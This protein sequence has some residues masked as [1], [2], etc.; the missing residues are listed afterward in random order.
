MTFWLLFRLTVGLLIRQRRTLLLV[1]L[2]LLP[3][4]LALLYRLAADNSAEDDHDFAVALLAHLILG[5]VLPLTA[6]VVGTAAFGNELEDGTAVYLI[7]KPVPRRNIVLAKIAAAWLAI[8]VMM[9][10]AVIATAL[11]V[12]DSD[13]AGLLRAFA[14]AATVGALAYAALFVSLSIRFGRA[15][16]IGLV[17]VIVWETLI[18][19][20]VSGV[21]F[22]SVRAYITSLADAL[23]DSPSRLFGNSLSPTAALTLLVVLAVLSLGLGI[24]RLNRYEISER[25]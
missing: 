9:L 18:S 10:P 4:G 19:Q 11:M 17:Y 8:V 5:L 14:V 3:I 12:G 16:I 7:A 25:V 1:L 20:F 23:A 21:R 15:L 6:L 2:A 24:R 22:L 13:E